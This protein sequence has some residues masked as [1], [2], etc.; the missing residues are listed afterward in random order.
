MN[1]ETQV[2]FPRLDAESENDRLI[3][4]RSKGITIGM[5]IALGMLAMCCLGTALGSLLSRWLGI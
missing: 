5:A 4:A 2:F 1:D 3:Q